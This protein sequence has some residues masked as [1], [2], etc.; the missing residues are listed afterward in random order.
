VNIP[1][2]FVRLEKKRPGEEKQILNLEL[3]DNK[4]RLNKQFLDALP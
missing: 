4:H 3:Y 1:I 2:R